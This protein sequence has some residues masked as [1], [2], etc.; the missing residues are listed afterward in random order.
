MS[1]FASLAIVL[2]V[3]LSPAASAAAKP[4]ACADGRFLLPEG[5][6]VL[7][8]PAASQ[9]QGVSLAS[10]AIGIEGS[11]EPAHAKVKPGRRGTRVTA[12]WRACGDFKKVALKGVIAA[13]GCETLRGQLKARKT[14]RVDFEATRSACGDGYVDVAGGE[15]CDL[16]V[17]GSEATLALL[18]A[19]HDAIAAGATD[20]ALSA[21]GTLRFRRSATA[22]GGIDEIV[23]GA[24]TLVR[25]VHDGDDTI[26]TSDADGDGVA[27]ITIEA[28]R[29]PVRTA[30]VRYDLDGDG[31]AERTLSMSQVGADGLTVEIT[32]AGQAPV[33]FSA[34]LLQEARTGAAAIVATGV[35]C[36][37]GELASA[38]ATL[39]TATASGFA[40]L[41]SLGLGGVEKAMAGKLAKDGVEFRCGAAT[42]CAQVDILDGLTGGLIPTAIGM[43]LGTSFFT[44]A[45]ACSNPD[46]VL[47]HE[48]LHVG[49]GES[50]SPFLD[51]TTFEGLATDR[52][53]SC[54][55]LCFRPGLATKSECATCLGVDR[56][57]AKCSTYA[58]GPSDPPCGGTVDIT[59]TTCPSTACSCCQDC[60]AGTKFV[61]TMDG[62]A[63]GPVDSYVRINMP[64]NFGGQISCGSW[65]AVTCPGV[66]ANILACCQRQAGEPDTTTFHGTL[67]F[68]FAGISCICPVPPS[69]EVGQLV[70]QLVTLN[71]GAVAEDTNPITCP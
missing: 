41:R 39:A 47:F 49:L 57:D 9:R 71:G 63:S 29:A 37:A 1:C 10:R 68:P 15:T 6:T 50:H 62:T 66:S 11:C 44:G 14:A 3:L 55:D 36:T 38:Q 70:A 59:S 21:D 51:R 27:E 45:G 67:P 4:V 8:A 54:T 48:L 42:G 7:T 26:M 64:P 35:G 5:A 46:M 60:P 17:D 30:V 31:S 65:S 16:P 34:P 69:M 18:D 32:L 24:V 25:W 58:D 33:G 28:Q 56:C 23:R 61:E 2:A 22:T 19:A 40:C 20:V 52:V 12:R 53:Y 13:P 43:N